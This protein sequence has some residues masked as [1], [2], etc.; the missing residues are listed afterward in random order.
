MSELHIHLCFVRHAET[1][2][3][4]AGIRQVIAQHTL[5]ITCIHLV[6]LIIILIIF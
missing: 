1:E 2:A 4:V 5:C 6:T 3:N